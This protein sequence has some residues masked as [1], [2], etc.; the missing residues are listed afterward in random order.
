MLFR[1]GQWIITDC[2]AAFAVER[3]AAACASALHL[4]SDVTDG[5]VCFTIGGGLS[6]ELL[7]K[8]CS[9]DLHPGAFGLGA[10]A[11]TLL[12][13]VPVL[14]YRPGGAS[15]DEAVF[16]LYADISVAWHLRRW[17]QDAALEFTI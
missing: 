15:D 14:L 11:Q 17:F 6:R 7:A 16:R 3:V 10:C 2:P 5:R 9:L 1:S 8:G 13:Q 12:A 4:V